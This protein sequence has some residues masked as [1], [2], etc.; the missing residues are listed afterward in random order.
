MANLNFTDYMR[1]LVTGSPSVLS[2][3]FATAAITTGCLGPN[4]FA[5]ELIAGFVCDC[6]RV[7][8]TPRMADPLRLGSTAIPFRPNV[9]VRF[10]N[11][12][13]R[14]APAPRR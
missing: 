7:H 8:S 14:R 2:A 11:P 5:N 12:A 1:D 4:K 6:V 13:L 9:P 10:F 3:R